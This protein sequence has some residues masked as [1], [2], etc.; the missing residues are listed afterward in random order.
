[1]HG[2]NSVHSEAGAVS[3]RNTAELHFQANKLCFCDSCISQERFTLH[4]CLK[5]CI[6]KLQEAG[7]IVHLVFV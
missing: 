2:C 4:N 1:M 3:S 6:I 7:M 5:A